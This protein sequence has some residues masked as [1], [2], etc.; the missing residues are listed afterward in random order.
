MRP[1]VFALAVCAMASNAAA[2]KCGGAEH[3]QF[4]FWLGN[5]NIEQ[6][7]A[8][9]NGQ[10]LRFPA[11]TSVTLAAGGDG[12]DKGSSASAAGTQ[13]GASCCEE[14]KT[15]SAAGSSEKCSS[16]TT[17]SLKGKVD[18][19]PYRENK[20]VVLA[21]TYACGHC[22][23]EKTEDCSPMLKTADGKVYPL[24]Q[25]TQAKD[26]R[27]KEGKSLEVSGTV[28]KVDGVKFLDVKSYKV[29]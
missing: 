2:G 7:I 17:A 16:A 10:T 25:N 24:L 6:E 27:A 12:C 9:A 23:L 22:T 18:D 8:A 1:I 26:M 4:D 13:G 19:M 29:I 21:G 20:R 28:K 3:R 15:A 14:G 11:T 5:W